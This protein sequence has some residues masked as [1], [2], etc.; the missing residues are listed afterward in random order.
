MSIEKSQGKRHLIPFIQELN[1]RYIETLVHLN[2]NDKA[3]R[4]N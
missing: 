3:A 1:N 2:E 4:S